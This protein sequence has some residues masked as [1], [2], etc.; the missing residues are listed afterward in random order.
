MIEC[1]K[2]RRELPKP[3]SL[4][5]A[6][7]MGED[8]TKAY[9]YRPPCDHFILALYCDPIGE[10]TGPSLQGPRS[11]EQ[12]APKMAIIARCDKPSRV[13]CTGEAHWEYFGGW[14]DA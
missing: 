11:H 5:N 10:E 4:I 1:L 3:Q 8:H 13:R 2:C 14:L 7:V 6:R 9:D 12:A